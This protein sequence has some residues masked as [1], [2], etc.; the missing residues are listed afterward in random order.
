MKALIYKKSS[1]IASGK[2]CASR[3]GEKEEIEKKRLKSPQREPGTAE[4]EKKS[5]ICGRSGRG[6]GKN[7]KAC[8]LRS[9]A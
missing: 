8:R 6:R 7:R 5:L 4:K 2:D 9:E 1:R 3:A